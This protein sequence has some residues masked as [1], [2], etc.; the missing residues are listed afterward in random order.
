M[1]NKKWMLTLLV[2]QLPTFPTDSPGLSYNSTANGRTYLI[3]AASSIEFSHISWCFFTSLR[4]Q[5]KM[6]ANIFRQSNFKHELTNRMSA[7]EC[8]DECFRLH[9]FRRPTCTS[10]IHITTEGSVL[11]ISSWFIAI[12]HNFRR[13]GVEGRKDWPSFLH[14]S[15]PPHWQQRPSVQAT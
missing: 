5:L 14:C 13:G 4:S 10:Q 11:V 1:P 3:T 9:S 7:T 2:K 8:T 12:R 6:I 15:L